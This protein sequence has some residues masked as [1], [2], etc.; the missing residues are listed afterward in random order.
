M[1]Y[2]FNTLPQYFLPA[3]FILI[4]I[5]FLIF[6]LWMF[7]RIIREVLKA[8]I[9][10]IRYAPQAAIF[11]F[12]LIRNVPYATV[13]TFRFIRIYP[14][15][16]VLVAS[17]LM[18]FLGVFFFKWDV[19][20]L[21]ILYWFESAVVGFYSILKL[22]KAAAVSTPEEINELR[23]YRINST[24]AA[25][26][27]KEGGLTWF[28]IQQ[29]GMFMAFH[30]LFLGIFIFASASSKFYTPSLL[31][32]ASLLSIFG[33]V[34]ALVTSHGIS[35]AMNF[36]GKQEFL[37]ISPAGQMMR[38]YKRIGIMHLTIVFGGIFTFLFHSTAAFLTVLIFSKIALDIFYH[39]KERGALPPWLIKG[40]RGR[41]IIAGSFKR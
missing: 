34:A 25:T 6:W 16:L 9:K 40:P 4:F 22:Q 41:M 24:S 37:S 26:A 13:V 32:S 8:A 1:D 27:I 14:S 21:L 12:R 39:L 15:V 17:N 28:F 19:F 35:Y 10:V 36:I 30:A 20:S 3:L 5:S 2:F 23:G 11:T 31:T 38:P 29:Y 18:P 33:S 7:F